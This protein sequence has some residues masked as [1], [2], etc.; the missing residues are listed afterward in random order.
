MDQLNF[1]S[2]RLFKVNKIVHPATIISVFYGYP[3]LP[4]NETGLIDLLDFLLGT[5][6]PHDVLTVQLVQRQCKKTLPYLKE[7]FP[8]L[9]HFSDKYS[10]EFAN[11]LNNPE[12]KLK[13][14]DQIE[15]IFGQ[16]LGVVKIDPNCLFKNKPKQQKIDSSDPIDALINAYRPAQIYRAPKFIPPFY[17][18]KNQ[19][20]KIEGDMVSPQ[21]SAKL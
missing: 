11:N 2:S 21:F 20:V 12:Y 8:D 19:E 17:L 14:L 5:Q 15:S 9:Y 13:L 16:K 1:K 4:E 3:L 7:C 6:M 10:A 18:H